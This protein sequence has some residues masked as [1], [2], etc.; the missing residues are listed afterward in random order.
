M[1]LLNIMN[2]LTIQQHHLNTLLKTFTQTTEN[3]LTILKNNTVAIDTELNEGQDGEFQLDLNGGDALPLEPSGVRV[4]V[5][6]C[7]M[8][9]VKIADS[10]EGGLWSVR[11]SIV[12]KNVSGLEVMLVGPFVYTASPRNVDMILSSLFDVLGVDGKT[13]SFHQTT[14]PKLVGNLF[15]KVLQLHASQILEGGI[16]LLDGALT[17]GPADSPVEVV[18]RIVESSHRNGIGV[19]AFSKSTTLTLQ[20]RNILSVAGSMTPPYVVK[21]P[22]RKTERWPVYCGSIYVAHLSPRYF[23]FRVDVSA[24]DDVTLLN[25]LLSSEAIIYGYP[26]S[27]ILAHQLAKLTRL[28]ILS[29]CARLEALHKIKFTQ[30]PSLRS[31]LFGPLTHS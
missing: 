7:D 16:L 22:P 15:E 3:S 5:V 12:R 31:I 26:E 9:T 19:A 4:P 18:A 1:E 21:L 28:D 2:N 8:S 14:A 17:A 24:A 13:P 30:T 27:L 11:G 23:P 10:V 20:G 29:I 6:A 25:H